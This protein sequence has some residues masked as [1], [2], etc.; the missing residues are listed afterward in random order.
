M[1][2]FTIAVVALAFSWGLTSSQ[3]FA[4][5]GKGRECSSKHDQPLDKKFMKKMHMIFIYQDELGVTD[6][7][8]AQ[9]KKIKIATKKSLIEKQAAIDVL[10]VDIRSSLHNP[11]IDLSAINK[12]IDKKYEIKKA[13]SKQVV[14]SIAE[15]KK[16]LTKDQL[17]QLKAMMYKKP[18]GPS[19]GSH[20]RHGNR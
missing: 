13:K 1:S 16:I 9:L 11:E 15:L 4:C 7:Q 19:E 14:A 12:L 3:T 5:S 18:Q 8:L 2:R 17:K 20:G 10:K 6:E